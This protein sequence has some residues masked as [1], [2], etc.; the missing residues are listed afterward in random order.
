[1]ERLTFEAGLHSNGKLRCTIQSASTSTWA[2]LYHVDQHP[3]TA[4]LTIF[5]R[6]PAEI[7]AFRA[8]SE[9]LAA[10]DVVEEVGA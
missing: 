6:T 3:N 1:M 9:A 4:P 2:Y 10:Q 8:L 5:I 7:A